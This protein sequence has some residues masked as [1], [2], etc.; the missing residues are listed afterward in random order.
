MAP[1]QHAGAELTAAADQYAF[2]VALWEGLCRAPPFSGSD[3]MGRKHDGPPRW[4][5]PS[6][7]KPIVDAIMRGL[8]VDRGQRWPTMAHLLRALDYDPARRS[9]Q[10]RMLAIAGLA[11]VMG[12]VGVWSW[13]DARRQRCS[14]ES[15]QLALVGVWD[16]GRHQ[17][18]EAAMTAVDVPYAYQVW[19]T[20]SRT[21]DDY[22]EDWTSARVEACRNATIHGTEPVE[23]MDLKMACLHRAGL[24]LRAA[25]DVLAQA[26]A[27]VLTQADRVLSTVRPVSR[28]S[29]VAALKA[30]VEPP[31]AREADAVDRARARIAATVADHGAGRYVEADT[32]LASAQAIVSTLEYVPVHTELALAEGLL[33]EGTGDYAGSVA[34]YRRAIGL[35][36]RTHQRR[37]LGQAASRLTFVI[38]QRQQNVELALRY[39]PLARA[40]TRGDDEAESAL[41]NSVAGVLNA[42]GR[43][44]DAELELRRALELEERV[45]GSEHPFVA[46]TRNNLAINLNRQGKHVEAEAMHRETLAVRIRILGPDHPHTASSHNNLAAS[47]QAQGKY[48]EAESEHRKALSIRLRA[49]EPNHPD[50]A[51]SHNNLATVLQAL[52][53]YEEAEAEN[54]RALAMR[55]EALGPDHPAVASSLNNIA[56]ALQSQGK[57]EAAVVEHRRALAISIRAF[58]PDH[59]AVALSRGNLGLV[60]Q[61]LGHF[62]EAELEH[63]EALAIYEKT[64]G[65]D[66]PDVAMGRQ[67]LADLLLLRGEAAEALPLARAAWERRRRDDLPPSERAATA[68]TLAQALWFGGS[69]DDRAEAR[70]L[71]QGALDD[72]VVAGMDD[73]AQAQQVRDWLSGQ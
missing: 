1:E 55:I 2:C 30:E 5:E 53:K 41:H 12:V 34:A 16:H 46:T 47:L 9:S 4:P 44:H 50:I 7:P 20:T 10:R 25:I 51:A 73:S 61:E 29:D 70:S 48:E 3:L 32:Q 31:L 62:D 17:E 59:L 39:L 18:V 14:V 69:D 22:A 68:F 13:F 15:A 49:L 54:R 56:I 64:L 52:G 19:L 60:L 45:Y 72:F 27:K 6:T 63:R 40:S 66:H 8:R 65:A 26:D 71:A 57:R 11:A 42:A 67:N 33:L 58:G 28:C 35:A 37:E 38:G 23:V 21:L 43:Y 36:S 24:E